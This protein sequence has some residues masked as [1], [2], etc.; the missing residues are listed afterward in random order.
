MTTNRRGLRSAADVTSP[1]RLAVEDRG[2]RA[3]NKSVSAVST[4]LQNYVERIFTLYEIRKVDTRFP[5]SECSR[6][7]FN[8]TVCGQVE[9]VRAEG[10]RIDTVSATWNDYG[11][12]RRLHSLLS[13]S[14]RQPTEHTPLVLTKRYCTTTRCR[15]LRPVADSVAQSLIYTL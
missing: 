3:I 7:V 1:G 11:C 5:R 10:Y 13:S 15:Q 2:W 9:K 4:E 6:Q 12:Q 14:N 8:S